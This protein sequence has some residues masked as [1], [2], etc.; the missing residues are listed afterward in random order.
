[1]TDFSVGSRYFKR[2]SLWYKLASQN[3]WDQA[4]ALEIRLD[5]ADV[6]EYKKRYYPPELKKSINKLVIK[7]NKTV[8]DWLELARI[9]SILGKKEESI[10]AVS[11]AKALDPV[12]DDILQL[13]Y[14]SIK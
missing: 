14:K 5:P 4:I 3:R 13:Y 6:V 9:Y 8:E 2:L 10:D 11:K 12:R 7:Q 1:M